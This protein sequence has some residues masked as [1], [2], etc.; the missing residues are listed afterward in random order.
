[1]SCQERVTNTSIAPV[2]ATPYDPF[3][4]TDAPKHPAAVSFMAM[5]LDR[6]GMTVSEL[7]TKLIRD[8]GWTDNQ[9]RQVHRWVKGETS[10]RLEAVFVLLRLAGAD[11][12]NPIAALYDQ[13]Q[14]AEKAT[15]ALE[16]AAKRQEKRQ[17][18]LERRI[19]DLEVSR[20]QYPEQPKH[21]SR[22][23]RDPQEFE[24]RRPSSEEGSSRERGRRRQ[25]GG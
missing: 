4:M 9:A 5:I 8:E 16:R 12:D 10:P 1:M 22:I 17:K 20:R 11:K 6:T 19:L 24:S 18:E 13:L 21:G 14:A 25:A 23:P 2:S 3:V 7:N 15:G